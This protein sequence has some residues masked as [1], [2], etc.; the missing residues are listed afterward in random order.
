MSN[1][2]PCCTTFNTGLNPGNPQG[3]QEEMDQGWSQ[4]SK[5]TVGRLSATWQRRERK[6]KLG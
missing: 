6:E 4:H 2:L 1:C 3:K 5:L